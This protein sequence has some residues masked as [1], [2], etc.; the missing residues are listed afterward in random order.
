MATSIEDLIYVCETPWHGLG[1]EYTQPP[2]SSNDMIQKANLNWLVNSAPM[3]TDIHGHI[4]GYHAIYREDT[5]AVL[6]VVNKAV[7]LNVIQNDA[8]FMTLDDLIGSRLIPE[9]AGSLQGGKIV[10]GCFKLIDTY[11]ILNDAIEYYIIVMNEHLKPD[12]NVTILNVPVNA[13]NQN[14][15]SSAISATTYKSRLPVTSDWSLKI[16]YTNKLFD[17]IDLCL[18]SLTK[19][20][21][22]MANQKLDYDSI[23][24]ILDNL[25]PYIPDPGL[26][27]KALKHNANIGMLRDVFN[28]CMK[29]SYLSDYAG[30]AYQVF[31]AVIDFETHYF[32]RLDQICNLDY[33][34]KQL[35]GIGEGPTLAY[36]FLSIKDKLIK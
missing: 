1:A 34:M 4:E 2:R 10:F 29:K 30:T 35:K 15:L 21:E 25:F 32:K 16:T 20:I 9:T 22:A 36:K 13:S 23:Q 8:S 27:E 17:S 11:T 12:G 19:C 28:Q 31:N 7:G 24:T 3:T 6:G 14:V 26:D 5:Q 33:R 18:S